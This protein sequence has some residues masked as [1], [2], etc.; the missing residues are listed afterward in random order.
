MSTESVSLSIVNLRKNKETAIP[1]DQIYLNLNPEFQRKYESWDDK[2]K[3]RFIET[4][5][6]GRAMNPIWTVFNEDENSEE[7][8]DGMHRLTTALAY[9]T[10]SF[11]IKK[12]HLTTLDIKKYNKVFFKDL[13][14][15]DQQKIR[16]YNFTFN[17]LDATYR[18]DTNKL[19]DMYEIL[20]RSSSSLN[21][22]EFNKV[23]LGPFYNVINTRRVDFINTKLF[24]KIKDKRGKLETEIIEFFVLSHDLDAESWS[25]ISSLKNK[26]I[27]DNLGSTTDDV[28][29][30]ILDNNKKITDMI[31]TILKVINH[32]EQLKL[33]TEKNTTIV[34]KF[35]I[36][37]CCKLDNMPLF[38]RHS[39]NL[40][41]EFKKQV[42]IDD[43]LGDLGC[44]NRNSQFQK[45]ILERIDSI[46][47]KEV[48]YGPRLFQKKMIIKKLKEQNNICTLCK[49]IITE[50]QEREG[51]HIKSWRSGGKTEESNLQVIHKMCHKEKN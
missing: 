8:L 20:N 35:I 27:K 21:D 38:Y 28:N 18:N 40:C 9:L 5:L 50:D 29:K 15:T 22:Y 47:K 4:I 32:L 34:H 33:Y 13:E 31:D 44:T 23:I 6:L 37:R 19:K 26:W 51:D 3:T 42:L 39:K 45:K 11:C 17:K 36:A 2:L 24:K 10:G 46:I 16:N 48:D 1:A 43:I 12:K 49:N 14:K 7:V 25:S 30:Y 41:A